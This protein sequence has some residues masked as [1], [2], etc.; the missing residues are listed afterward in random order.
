MHDHGIPS[1][2]LVQR[3]ILCLVL[4]AHPNALSIPHV[5]REIDAGDA[6]EVAIRDLVGHGV[7]ECSGIAVKAAP[8]IVYFESLELP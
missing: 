6:A 3:A 4:D 5:A 7:L 1:A 8:A 2:R